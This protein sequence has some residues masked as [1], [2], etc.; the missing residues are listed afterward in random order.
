MTANAFSPSLVDTVTR[1]FERKRR[2]AIGVPL[3]IVAYL[4]YAAI[5]FDIAGLIGRARM[6]NAA[7]LLSDFWSHKTHVS[8][9][10]RSGT[11]EV[12]IEGESKGTYL[13]GM[14]PEINTTEPYSP[15]PPPPSRTRRST[16]CGL[17]PPDAAAG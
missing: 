16:R 13:P 5:S 2:F 4:V 17:A 10:N 1:S 11:V 3:V 7:I 14:L 8:R 15:T 6:D 9:D 12:A